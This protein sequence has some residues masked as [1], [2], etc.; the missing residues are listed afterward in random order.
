MIVSF[1]IAALR[2]ARKMALRDVAALCGVSHETVRAVEKGRG[3]LVT[4]EAIA[5]GLSHKIALTMDGHLVHF[6]GTLGRKLHQI[7]LM[8][9]RERG[10]IEGISAATIKDIESDAE[11]VRLVS[12]ELYA[13]LLGREAGVDF[14]LEL[15][16]LNK[17]DRIILASKENAYDR[18]THC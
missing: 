13:A 14:R 18:R 5:L 1:D 7:R 15:K 3:A 4:A 6:P 16:P 8:V 11:S 17:F 9:R 12:V 2:L 10:D